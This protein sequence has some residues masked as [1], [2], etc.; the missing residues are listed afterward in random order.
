M[1]D[2]P[3]S[4]EWLTVPQACETLK[5]SERTL[6]RRI[7]QGTYQTKLEHGRRFVSLAESAETTDNTETHDRRDGK[8]LIE[9]LHSEVSHLRGT[10]DRLTAQLTEAS[11]RSDTIILHLSQQLDRAHLQLEDSRERR[12]IWQRMK[13]VFAG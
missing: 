9:Q 11:K 8:A 4:V 13:A 6:R 7:F 3:D 2:I 1:A 5:V 10:V 12:S